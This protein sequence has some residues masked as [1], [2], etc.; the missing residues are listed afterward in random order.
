MLY[1]AA[2]YINFWPRK[3]SKSRVGGTYPKRYEGVAL[4]YVVQC[5]IVVVRE[6]RCRILCCCP[7]YFLWSS[8]H[9][10]LSNHNH[11]QYNLLSDKQHDKSSIRND[12]FPRPLSP[13]SLRATPIMHQPAHRSMDIIIRCMSR[14][15]GRRRRQHCQHY[16]L[17]A[18][19]CADV[20]ERW[21]RCDH[22]AA[23]AI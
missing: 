14:M 12:G 2:Q 17:S 19:H 20:G 7:S 23:A 6:A 22:A 3:N 18:E 5:K 1:L 8:G 4:L 15:Q 13:P 16:Q 10:I 11:I 21:R 9:F